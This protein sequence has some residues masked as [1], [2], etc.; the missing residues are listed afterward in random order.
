MKS[1]LDFSRFVDWGFMA[2]LSTLMTFAV[3]KISDLSTSINELNTKMEVVITSNAVRDERLSKVERKLE[4]LENK[5]W[6]RN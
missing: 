1:R 4:A 5:V 2:I 6:K 3:D